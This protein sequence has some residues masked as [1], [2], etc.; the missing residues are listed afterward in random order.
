MNHPLLIPPSEVDAPRLLPWWSY[1]V[2][3]PGRVL[4]LSPFGDWFLEQPDGTVWRLDLLEGSFDKIALSADEF[5][6]DLATDT[7]EDE[8][9]QAGTVMALHRQGQPRQPGQCYMYVIHPRLGATVDKSNVK[10]G[11]IGAWQLICSQLHPQLDAVPK[12]ATITRLDCDTDGR[13]TVEWR[14]GS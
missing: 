14:M 5:W 9:L 2:P 6:A 11:D 7:G 8:W 12:G 4:G 13:L 10:L 1:L 3:H